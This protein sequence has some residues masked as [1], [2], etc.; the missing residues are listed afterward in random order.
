MGS[1][2]ISASPHSQARAN[3][4]L[5]SPNPHSGATVLMP[6]V[7]ASQPFYMHPET[8]T[9]ADLSV[10]APRALLLLRMYQYIHALDS[11]STIELM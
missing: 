3:I 8:G 10:P 5:L 4:I 9:V 11:I 7:L 2:A 6:Q 1:G